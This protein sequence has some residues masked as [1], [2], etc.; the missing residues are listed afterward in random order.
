[1]ASL[2]P[3]I[4]PLRVLPKPWPR[5]S[6]W[7]LL[8][9]E[10]ALAH[11]P[12]PDYRGLFGGMQLIASKA[13]H[14]E[15]TRLANQY[16]PLF[17]LRIMAFHVR[18]RFHDRPDSWA[19]AL[20]VAR[21]LLGYTACRLGSSIGVSASA[22]EGCS[23]VGCV[24]SMEQCVME[25]RVLGFNT[26]KPISERYHSRSLAMHVAAWKVLCWSS[27]KCSLRAPGGGDHRP[28]AGD[29][30]AAQPRPRQAEVPVLVPGSGEV[31]VLG[32][33]WHAGMLLACSGSCDGMPH[34]HGPICMHM[35]LE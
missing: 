22:C 17:K 9:R 25:S 4:K 13:V 19:Q 20:S 26:L 29:G 31:A 24:T 18:P 11:L 1:M 23:T 34:M 3:S 7:E 33:C 21:A 14:R 2:G 8:R 32:C 30:G 35:L 10:R 28:R 6:A 27:R 5:R 12:G 15:A 16:G